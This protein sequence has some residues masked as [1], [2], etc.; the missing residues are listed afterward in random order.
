M[1]FR[2]FLLLL[3]LCFACKIRSN[4]PS[5]LIGGY[6]SK[7]FNF[8]ERFAL[9]KKSR[10]PLGLKKMVLNADSTYAITGDCGDH[11]ISGFWRRRGKDSLV[12]FCK[13]NIRL[14]DSSEQ[15][16]GDR[17]VVFFISKD[18]ELQNK[19]TVTGYDFTIYE[20]FVKEE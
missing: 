9:P 4:A 1:I 12:F 10:V 17:P 6:A 7:Q 2:F 5:S 16:C 18:G 20:Y 11:I 15:S 3:I 8:F 13:S 19:Y 14:R